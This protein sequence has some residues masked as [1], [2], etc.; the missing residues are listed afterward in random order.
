MHKFRIHPRFCG[1]FMHHSLEM[2]PLSL[3]AINID[4]KMKFYGGQVGRFAWL[5]IIILPGKSIN[6]YSVPFRSS[7]FPPTC[8][9]YQDMRLRLTHMQLVVRWFRWV[10]WVRW[11]WWSCYSIWWWQV[12]YIP[13]PITRIPRFLV[14]AFSRLLSLCCDSIY[15]CFNRCGSFF[16]SSHPFILASKNTHNVVTNIC[17]IESI[18]TQFFLCNNNV[19][20]NSFLKGFKRISRVEKING[21]HLK[22]LFYRVQ[23]IT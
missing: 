4:K 15:L 5:Y 19:M 3:D 14:P 18:D 23:R 6:F 2:C 16:L 1:V 8:H 21:N 7:A 17:C 12:Y 9:G 22:E 13:P 11:W 20:R 10:R